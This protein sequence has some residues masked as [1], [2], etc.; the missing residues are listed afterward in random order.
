MS[1][2]H[3]VQTMSLGETERDENGS[4]RRSVALLVYLGII[5]A[6]FVLVSSSAVPDFALK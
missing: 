5:G 4:F 3:C 6:I 2:V 1:P